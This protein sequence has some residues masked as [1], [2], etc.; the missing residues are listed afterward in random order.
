MP[1]QP[2]KQ[3]PFDS[4]DTPAAI[5]VTLLGTGSSGGVPRVGGQWGA[6]DPKNPKNRR[7]RCA[8]LATL[9][10]GQDTTTVVV[11]AGADLREQ[12]LSANVKSIDA[13]LL[14][15]PHAD[16]IFGLDDLRQ[17]ALF[18]GRSIDVY[19][20]E[21]TSAVV[22][23][24]FGYC[25]TQAPG[26]SYPSFCTERRICYPDSIDIQG[27]AGTLQVNTLKA[28][29]GDIHAL[30]FR[31]E[32][33]VYLPDI[34]RIADEASYEQLQHVD[35]LIIDALRYKHH[36]A[37]MNVDDA[38]DFIQRV[39]PRQAILTNM[40]SDLDFEQLSNTLPAGVEPGFDGMQ[41]SITRA[42]TRNNQP[43]DNSLDKSRP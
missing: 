9:C 21:S 15:H 11:D 20:D 41:L 25:F 34:K 24:C 39:Q 32:D 23:Q 12:L 6:C 17:M 42:G 28:E 43:G 18:T 14:T 10:T 27:S 29:H 22:M 31:I 16:H 4:P 26:S 30:G 19:M 1:A 36:P 2:E 33:L 35:T 7:M 38:L 8:L 3:K 37:H 5:T 13:V 40:H